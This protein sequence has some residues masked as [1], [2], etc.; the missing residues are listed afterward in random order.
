MLPGRHGECA[1]LNA[2]LAGVR[3]HRSAALVIRGEAG[4]GK[5]ALLGYAAE[6]AGTSRVLRA[7]GVESEVELPFAAL[8][9]LFHHV[10]PDLDLLPAPQSA[11]LRT[12][13]GLAP[14]PGAPQNQPQNQAQ[15]QAQDQ[16]RNHGSD[17]PRGQP[18]EQ[19][20]VIG[21]EESRFLVAAG[22]LTLL[23]EL[24]GERGLL[25][26]VDDAHW[27]DGPS[28]D[29]LLF[30]ARRLEAEGV[31]LLFAAREGEQ[32]TFAAPG[33]PSLRLEGLDPATAETLLS[34][35][36]PTLAPGVRR[37]IVTHTAGNP[38]AL[39]E[40]PAALTPEQLAGRRPLPDPLLIGSETARLFTDRL[41]HLA[42]ATNRLLEVAAAD[43]TGDLKVILPAAAALGS[44]LPAL[45]A[46]EQAGL[47]T[48]GDGRLLFRHPLMRSAAYQH[49]TFAARRAVHVALAR[50]LEESDEPDRRAWHLAAAAIGPDESVAGALEES[51]GRA[52]RRGGPA[53][54]ATALERAAEL[55]PSAAVRGRRLVA[56]AHAFWSAGNPLR[57]TALL[58]HAEPLIEP[59]AQHTN[60]PAAPSTS[61]PH[62]HPPNDPTAPS[63]N[64]PTGPSVPSVNL[65]TGPAGQRAELLQLRGLIELRCGAPESAYEVL[66]ESAAHA[67]DGPA[68]LR[69]LVLAAEAASFSGDASRVV[70]VGRLAAGIG[71]SDDPIVRMLTG[72]AA[73][74][75][76]DW[77]A[78][79]RELRAVV[80]AAKGVDDPAA[81]LWVGR[82]ALYL[83]DQSMARA[84]HQRAVESARRAG[85]LGA[86]TTM[87]D[88]LA[89]SELLLG[90][91]DDAEAG[92]A[93]GLRL[94]EEIG[95]DEAVVHHLGILALAAAVRGDD[96]RCRAHAE[97]ALAGAAA[98]DIRLISALATWALGLLELGHARPEAALAHLL[99][100]SGATGHPALRLWSTPDLVEAAVRAGRPELAVA[101]Y[102]AY[103]Q[104][105]ARVDMPW[106]LAA[107]A[108]CRALLDGLP[109]ALDRYEE[110]LALLAPEPRPFDRAR[111]DFLCGEALRRAKRRG[112]ARTRLRA[113][114][115][116]FER[117]GAVP[118]AER[119]RAELRASGETARRRDPTAF[120]RLTPQERQIAEYAGRG[121]SNPEI[122]AAVFLSRRTVE[123][124][125][126]KVFTKLGITSRIDLARLDLEEL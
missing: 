95:Q 43:D 125:L 54:S 15:N 98:R 7:C 23:G 8:H 109:T 48:V 78:G 61:H 20:S 31:A 32:R 68:A 93:E 55:T 69:S 3:E 63:T 49:A 1:R 97:R 18:Q 85:A 51:A 76:G 116:T 6:H 33:L 10:G 86:L 40:L 90:R 102:E 67:A 87:L 42:P 65:S 66:V 113:A 17:Q 107:S 22:V 37:H 70:E 5:S 84:V 124:H 35:R 71:P 21:R 12:A 19:G 38:L 89:F 108:R 9:Q 118:W 83:G 4:I 81:L 79:A 13:L 24:S 16:A 34:D 88:R 75:S 73:V 103:D 105:A 100:L 64:P 60:P 92:A 101:Q 47:V 123:Y 122:A 44:G 77:A 26:L 126:S 99:E 53:A 29:A 91:P 82:A 114:L 25:C 59:P 41:T 62:P 117:L 56:A 94:A 115:E 57:A 58:L 50:A 52:A 106:A 104:W 30:A 14:G 74:F 112:E 80:A 2:L 28:A 111:T 45:Q 27:L 36:L 72:T 96:E 46:A 119:A 39:L 110:A 11:A 120:A 121:A